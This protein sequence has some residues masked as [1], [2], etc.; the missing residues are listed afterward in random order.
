MACMFSSVLYDNQE[1]LAHAAIK[2]QK[3]QKDKQV[4]HIK[5]LGLDKMSEGSESRIDGSGSGSG[6]L[7]DESS[8]DDKGSSSGS[9]SGSGSDSS[10]SDSDEDSDKDDEEESDGRAD[11]IHDW[12]QPEKYMSKKGFSNTKADSRVFICMG[13]D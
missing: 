10:E 12:S 6:S 11:T 4:R 5:K 1:E 7:S 3:D 9:D 2:M 8:K 13:K